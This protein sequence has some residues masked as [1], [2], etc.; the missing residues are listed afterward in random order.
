MMWRGQPGIFESEVVPR[1]LM[2]AA[3]L[4]LDALPALAPQTRF[5]EVQAGGGVLASPLAERIAGLGRLVSVD[6]DDALVFALPEVP[7]RATRVVGGFPRL[8]FHTGAFDVVCL[9][10]VLGRSGDDDLA[11]LRE[12]RRLVRPGGTVLCTAIGDQSFLAL[13]DLVAE[14]AEARGFDDVVDAV[15]RFRS[16]LPSIEAV[17]ARLEAAGFAV[18]HCGAEDRLLGLYDG[19]NLLEDPLVR[20]VLLDDALDMDLPPSL[21]GAITAATDGWFAE[22]LALR[23]QTIVCAA[24]RIR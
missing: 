11:R 23:A 16:C 6:V 19:A 21:A 24:S 13:T 17:G 8:P 3:D 5:L 15:H 12:V 14:M 2:P 22:G 9:N 7:R 1:L 10:L 4:L 18:N 20:N